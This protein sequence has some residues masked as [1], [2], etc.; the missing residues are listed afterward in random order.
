MAEKDK[1][2]QHLSS[3]LLNELTAKDDLD[4]PSLAL[5]W[6]FEF[7]EWSFYAVILLIIFFICRTAWESASSFLGPLLA[8]KKPPTISAPAE[9]APPV[10]PEADEPGQPREEPPLG[11][12]HSSQDSL[13]D[14]PTSANH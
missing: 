14:S 3:K 4:K 6:L 2:D 10:E 8:E 12:E 5:F 1:D 11:E 9:Q 7:L 13:P